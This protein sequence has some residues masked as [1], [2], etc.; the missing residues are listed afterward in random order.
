VVDNDLSINTHYTHRFLDLNEEGKLTIGADFDAAMDGFNYNVG[1]TLAVEGQLTGLPTLEADRRLEAASVLGDM[2]VHGTFAP[3]NN[4]A[5]SV[6][7]GTLTMGTNGVL[8]MEA[9]Q[10]PSMVA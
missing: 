6:L 4:P 9:N 7:D 2:T 10:H 5:D 1:S 8:E 3:G